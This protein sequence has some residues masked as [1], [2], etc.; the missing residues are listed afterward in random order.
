MCQNYW[1]PWNAATEPTYLELM[2]RNERS[3]RNK[4]PMHSRVAPAHSNENLVQP[5]KKKPHW[6]TICWLKKY[7]KTNA[8]PES[9]NLCFI[10]R[11]Y[12]RLQPGMAVSQIALRD[13]S[14][15]V[16]KEPGYIGIFAGKKKHEVAHQKITANHKTDYLKLMISGLFCIWEDVR[17]WA[18]SII[19]LIH[20]LTT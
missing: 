4:K 18:Y 5:K 9:W 19:P 1:R 11:P 20:I 3:P 7:K 13:Y 16:R 10:Q 14:K 12:W 2:L 15:D 17:V 8:Q 6:D